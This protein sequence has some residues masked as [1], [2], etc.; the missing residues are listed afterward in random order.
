MKLFFMWHLCKYTDS[1]ENQANELQL[2]KFL[3]R[4]CLS[5]FPANTALSF[6]KNAPTESWPTM[7]QQWALGGRWK[8]QSYQQVVQVFVYVHFDLPRSP[9]QVAI[10]F[11][12]LS[13]R[14][15]SS[16][17]SASASSSS[18]SSSSSWNMCVYIYIY[19]D[20][21][22]WFSRKPLEKVQWFSTLHAKKENQATIIAKWSFGGSLLSKKRCFVS[23][24]RFFVNWQNIILT[25]SPDKMLSWLFLAPSP[26]KKA[27]Q[28]TH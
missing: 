27:L 3:A 2:S 11:P 24:A 13:L 5:K 20:Y 25:P 15:A 6:T 28:W 4:A 19:T 16:S 21:I 7:T 1:F 12:E 8:V 23:K 10:F 17:S 22:Y 26:K 14:V 18:S 9:K